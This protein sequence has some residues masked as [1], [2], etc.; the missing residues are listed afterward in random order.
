MSNVLGV[1]TFLAV[2]GLVSARLLRYGKFEDEIPTLKAA[3]RRSRRA[4]KDVIKLRCPDVYVSSFGATDIDPRHFCLCIDV[5]T[6]FERDQLKA[7]VAL[8]STLREAVR[9]EGYPEAAIPHITFSYESQETVTRDFYGNWYY[10]R[11]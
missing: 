8:D 4:V 3:I 2:V 10:A 6:D 7:D 5:Q 1:T 9:R 11:K